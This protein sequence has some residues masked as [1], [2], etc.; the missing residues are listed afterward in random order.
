[1][2][3]VRPSVAWRKSSYSGAHGNCVEVARLPDGAVG[4]RDGKDPAGPMLVLAAR[5]WD[6]FLRMVEAGHPDG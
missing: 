5:R 6:A 3:P 2:S 1:M 4:V